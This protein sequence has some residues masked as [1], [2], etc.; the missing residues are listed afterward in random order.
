[1]RDE[2]RVHLQGVVFKISQVK[3]FHYSQSSPF[4]LRNSLPFSNH[5]SACFFPSKTTFSAS[6]MICCAVPWMSFKVLP[7]KY[8]KLLATSPSG[9]CWLP[10]GDANVGS[11]EQSKASEE[12]TFLILLVFVSVVPLDPWESLGAGCLRLEVVLSSMHYL[13]TSRGPYTSHHRRLLTLSG[14]FND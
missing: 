3:R 8:P 13:S 14:L 11:A 7:A 1:M 4:C 5:F 10:V 9:T 2:I 6:W 12:N